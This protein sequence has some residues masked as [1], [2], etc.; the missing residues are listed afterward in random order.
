MAEIQERW[1]HFEAREGVVPV[2][3]LPMRDVHRCMRRSLPTMDHALR[4]FDAV[5]ARVGERGWIDPEGGEQRRR[6]LVRDPEHPD[7]L[8][9]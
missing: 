3:H 4:L 5:V 7:W 1:K 9:P 2:G 8:V 6:L